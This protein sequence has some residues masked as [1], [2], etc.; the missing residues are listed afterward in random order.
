MSGDWASA[1]VDDG[2]ERRVVVKGIHERGRGWQ[3]P[4]SLGGRLAVVR[5]EEEGCWWWGIWSEKGVCVRGV[6]LFFELCVYG[7]GMGGMSVD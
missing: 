1:E 6:G 4:S 3:G 5:E 2:R 7:V